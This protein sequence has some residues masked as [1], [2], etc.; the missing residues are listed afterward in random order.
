MTAIRVRLADDHTLSSQI[1]DRRRSNRRWQP[2][3]ALIPRQRAVCLN[4]LEFGERHADA[5]R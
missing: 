2:L 5:E 3:D 1:V 4:G